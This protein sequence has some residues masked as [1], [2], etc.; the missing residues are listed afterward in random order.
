[1]STAITKFNKRIRHK[2]HEVEH[3]LAA[4]QFSAETQVA[5]AD[6][7]IRAHVE[8]LEDGAHKAKLALG[9]AQTDMASW[10]DDAREV[11]AEWKDKLDAAMLRGRAERLEHYAEAALVVALAGVDQAE[12]AMLSAGLARGEAEAALTA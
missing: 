2:L 9:Q 4:L 6:K 8:T 3:R 1:M 5:H 12:K 11:V 10:V 7:A